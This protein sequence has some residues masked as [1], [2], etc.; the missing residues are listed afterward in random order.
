MTEEPQ[1]EYRTVP[2]VWEYRSKTH[3]YQ[4]KPTFVKNGGARDRVR[5]QR[6]VVGEW[7]DV[8]IDD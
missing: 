6:R 4:T 8:E 1:Y 3:Y 5:F 7:E 2:K